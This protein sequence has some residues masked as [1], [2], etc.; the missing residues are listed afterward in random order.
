MS[1]GSSREE[2]AGG[3]RPGRR[4]GSARGALPRRPQRGRGLE[5]GALA[6]SLAVALLLLGLALS[7]LVDPARAREA[8]I[9]RA[10][11]IATAD[12]EQAWSELLR[13][14]AWLADLDAVL[15]WS[16][17]ELERVAAR[18]RT[19]PLDVDAAKPSAAFR[20]LLADSESRELRGELGEALAAARDALALVPVGTE[21][22]QRAVALLRIVQLAAKAGDAAAARNA[23]SELRAELTGAETRRGLP[24]LV[25]A[26]LAVAPVLAIEERRE[27]RDEV[28]RRWT[29]GE[30]ALPDAPTN[31]AE[32]RGLPALPGVW[33][34]LVERLQQLVPGERDERLDREVLLRSVLLVAPDTPSAARTPAAGS[35]AAG[36]PRAGPN[37]AARPPAPASFEATRLRAFG[38]DVFVARTSGD[39]A[40][41]GWT[42]R[43]A[44]RDRAIARLAQA[45]LPEDG[46]AV[47]WSGERD[48]LGPSLGPWRTL[49]PIGIGF[50]LRAADRAA[51]G[52]RA[53]RPFVL[54]RAGLVVLAVLFALAG[55]ALFA[56]LRRDRRLQE[57][58]TRFVASVS[59][60]LRTPLASIL[61][62]AENLEHGRVP[63]DAAPTYHRSIRREAQ[64]LRRLVDD[65][66]DFSRL[67]RGERPQLE[68]ADTQLEPL[69]AAL[70]EEVHDRVEHAGRTLD[71]RVRDLAGSA[72]LDAEALRRAVLNLVDNALRHGGEGEVQLTARGGARL[73]FEVADRGPGVP[74]E[75]RERVFEPFA[76]LSRAHGANGASGGAGLGLSI[77]RTIAR[78][79]GGDARVRDREPGPGAVFELW[80]PGPDE[81]A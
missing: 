19:E 57:L 65:V 28:V 8:A 51:L 46:L 60:E 66:L 13:T 27:V 78:E 16:P 7:P 44:L 54:A 1:G 75:Q 20:A 70:A 40:R 9:A 23:W 4:A 30:L 55:S 72:R 64:R 61:L 63:A 37:A 12:V 76:Q 6:A 56:A 14:D 24:V 62:L 58:K 2:S 59:H 47:D 5:L 17:A 48:E 53:G 36:T 79:H 35:G 74:P 45:G 38:D 71:V 21:R 3:A 29:A 31:A 26:A 81:D 32:R 42:T 68:L 11:R 18:A 15:A 73:S 43:S 69:V 34:T 39:E 33:T 52:V 80:I 49:D 22:A 41:G 67:E 25:L 77:V 10:V 50:R